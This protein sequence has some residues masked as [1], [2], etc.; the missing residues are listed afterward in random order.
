MT[1]ARAFSVQRFDSAQEAEAAVLR[2]IGEAVTEALGLRGQA[3]I[4]G[5][6]GSTP[7]PVYERLSTLDLEWD[8]VML[9]QVDERFVPEDDERSNSKMMRE[10]VSGVPGLRFLSLIQDAD[11]AQSAQKAEDALRALGDGAAPEF[12]ITLLGMGGD[13]HY[14][15]IFPGHEIN[16]TVY[17]TGRIVLPVEAT[18]GTREPVWPRLTLSVSALNRSRRIVLYITGD[19]KLKALEEALANPDRD[20]APIGAFLQQYP[21]TVDIVWAAQSAFRK[22]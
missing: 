3:V 7:K 5:A 16:A 17:D 8:K 22:V 13:A 6:G 21:H 14:A 11:L 18:D 19:A 1:E 15:S 4:C 9:T 10:A 20:T 12:D 2:L